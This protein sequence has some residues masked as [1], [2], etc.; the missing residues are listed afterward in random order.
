[1]STLVVSWNEAPD[2]KLSDCRLA[3]VMPSSNVAAVAGRAL[4]ALAVSLPS[5]SALALASFNS[6][7]VTSA[8]TGSDVSPASLTRPIRAILS[9]AW[10]KRKRSTTSLGSSAQSPGFS[11]RTLR[12]IWDRITSMCLSLMF[13]PW[14]R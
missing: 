8:P 2:R 14:A 4:A 12:S 10:R 9:L 5:A 3:L 11:T 7:R 6:V 1:M 13:T